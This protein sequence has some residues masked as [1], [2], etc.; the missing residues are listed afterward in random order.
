M[1]GARYQIAVDDQ[2]RSNRD[3]KA[4][5]IEA[6]EYLKYKHPHAEVTVYD[7]MTG[8]T[9]TIKARPRAMTLALHRGGPDDYDVIHDG[10][11]VGRIYR[12]KA[13]RELWRWMIRL[14]APAPG[15]SGG[16]ICHPRRGDGGLPREVG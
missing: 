13:D 4:I 15:P 11:T 7:L 3:T 6:A 12:V 2:P 5:A 1:T 10:E 14:W 16:G 8:D 9:I